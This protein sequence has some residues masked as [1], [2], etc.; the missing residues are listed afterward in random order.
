MDN[1]PTEPPKEPALRITYTISE[2][3]HADHVPLRPS[4]DTPPSEPAKGA[5][6]YEKDQAESTKWKAELAFI[7]VF[8][9]VCLA[10][11]M[12]NPF[13]VVIGYVFL[14]MVPFIYFLI[15]KE[16]KKRRKAADAKPSSL[17]VVGSS[18][19]TDRPQVDAGSD[20]L[21]IALRVG[22]LT[23][24]YFCACIALIFAS[25]FIILKLYSWLHG[26]V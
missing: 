10:T 15:K 12:E 8:S 14:F 24:V 16:E 23:V 19:D 1:A 5:A 25:P 9:L 11:G 17:A 13:L 18:S 22:L 3:S 21:G 4:V 6:P 20:A 7:L 2:P 26:E